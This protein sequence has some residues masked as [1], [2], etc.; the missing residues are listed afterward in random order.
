[1]ATR[2]PSST[3]STMSGTPA[4]AMP[5]PVAAAMP[6]SARWAVPGGVEDAPKQPQPAS[7][8]RDRSCRTK[9][10]RPR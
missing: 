7:A 6:F 8:S 10:A 3:T 2:M 9:P 1:M 4:T 5:N